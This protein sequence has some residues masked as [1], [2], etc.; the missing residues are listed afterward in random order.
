M[1]MNLNLLAAFNALLEEG[2]VVGAAER[3]HLS[4]PA[5]SRTLG[6]IRGATGDPILIR[7]GRGMIP[8][9]FA[10]SVHDRVQALVREGNSILSPRQVLDLLTLKRTF[11]VRCHDAVATA[12]TAPLLQALHAE[13]PQVRLRI[14]PESTGDTQELRQ[15]QLDLE[16]GSALP[17]STELLGETIYQD[18]LVVAVRSGHPWCRSPLGVK[19]FAEGVHVIVSRR[20]RLRDPI[21]SMLETLGCRRD[22]AASLPSSTVAMTAVQ[23]SNMAAV[24]PERMC[25]PLAKRLG[26]VLLPVPLELRPVP[27]VMTWHQRQNFDPAHKWFRQRVRSGV[28]DLET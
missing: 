22:V 5:M 21:D 24:I 10:L 7:S 9:P 15:G 13:A 12:I 14:L 6:R 3:L 18:R 8:S 11:T 4:Q 25:G 19:R 17:P 23:A 1:H 16:I 27:L 2:S 20:G 26:L 28:L